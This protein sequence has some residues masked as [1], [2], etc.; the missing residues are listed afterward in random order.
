MRNLL[1]LENPPTAVL[2]ANNLMTLGGLTAI[3]ESRISIPDEIALIGF[4]DM[5]WA[6]SLQPPLSVISQP[7]FGMGERAAKLLLERI[8]EPDLAPRKVILETELI[9]RKSS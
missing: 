2:I 9:L 3:H 5:D 8:R 7:A 6:P 1:A 4:D